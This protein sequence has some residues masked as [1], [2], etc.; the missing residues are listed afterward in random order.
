MFCNNCGHEV[1]PE[2]EACSKCGHPFKKQGKKDKVVFV[3]LALLLGG[4]GIHRFYLGDVLL[5]IVYLLFCWTFIP[6]IIALV[7]AIVIGLRQDD[8]RFSR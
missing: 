2:A 6:S 1:S 7:E 8:E 5:G 3:L 4:L